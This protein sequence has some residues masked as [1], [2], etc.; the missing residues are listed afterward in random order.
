MQL[1][2]LKYQDDSDHFSEIRSVDIDGEFWFVGLDV[3]KAL[4]YSNASD[5]IIRHCKSRG[6]VKRDVPTNSEMQ[7]MTLINE[8]NVYRLIVKSKLES[9]EKFETWLKKRDPMAL[10]YLPKVLSA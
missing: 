6:I 2:L 8:P 7:Y 1:N 5:A 4:G 9:A 3:A 10:D